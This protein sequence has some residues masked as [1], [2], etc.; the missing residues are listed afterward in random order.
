MI[1]IRQRVSSPVNT[2]QRG[3]VVSDWL[4]WWTTGAH[5]VLYYFPQPD[6]PRHSPAHKALHWPVRP[7]SKLRMNPEPFTYQASNITQCHSI[8]NI[9]LNLRAHWYQYVTNDLFQSHH[10]FWSLAVTPPSR[11]TQTF[12]SAPIYW[13][14]EECIWFILV[15]KSG[16]YW[17]QQT[18]TKI[19]KGDTN[20]SCSSEKHISGDTT[21]C[22]NV[23]LPTM[24]VF[25]ILI[26]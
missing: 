25:W 19:E 4:H 24:S 10:E 17:Q 11:Y 2:S 1:F 6:S 26:N 5:G 13:C 16:Q 23:G 3:K 7:L 14:L 12:I 21:Y 20:V 15:P 22:I 18:L 9:Y 8:S